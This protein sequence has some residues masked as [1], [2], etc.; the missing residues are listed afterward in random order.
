MKTLP[1]SFYERNPAI[2][3][4][5]LLGKVLVRKLNHQTLSGKIVETEA[6]YGEK[7]P[8]SKAYEGRK[9]FNELMFSDAGKAFIYMVHGNWL[10]NIVAHPKGGVGAVLIRAV[11]PIQGIEVM[12][13]NRGVE[14]I[15]ALTSGPGRLTKALSITK[16]Q[17][18]LDVTRA[19]N[20][21]A[22]FEATAEEFEICTSHRIGVKRDLP[23]ELRFYIK[24]NRFVSKP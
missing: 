23:Q 2:V 3:A 13:K 14:D 8:A 12:M 7:D 4:R 21:I 16:K 17:N 1:K 6:Y 10:L 24:E 20:E 9:A 5:E 22:I 11:E 18:G 19:E 15:Y